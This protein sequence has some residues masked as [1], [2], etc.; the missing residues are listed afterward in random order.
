MPLCHAHAL[1]AE[2]NRDALDRDAGEQQ[3]NRKCVAEPMGVSLRYSRQLEQL[4]EPLPPT[5]R[6]GFQVVRTVPEEVVFCDL[7]DCVER[8]KNPFWYSLLGSIPRQAVR[9]IPEFAR[10]MLN[11]GVAQGGISRG[12]RPRMLA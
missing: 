3:F 1:M 8:P 2:Q 7:R 11:S 6:D 10:N 5:A 12:I 9:L 4:C